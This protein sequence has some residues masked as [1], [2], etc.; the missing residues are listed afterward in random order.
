M[1]RA[2]GPCRGLL[3]DE[4]QQACLGDDSVYLPSDQ[5]CRHP[6]VRAYLVFRSLKM[7]VS[8]DADGLI[9][10]RCNDHALLDEDASV[11]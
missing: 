4:V 3:Y 6:V 10:G 1:H 2:S 9:V 7:R 11:L 8:F 5:G